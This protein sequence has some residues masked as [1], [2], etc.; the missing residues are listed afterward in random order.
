[1][2]LFGAVF[3]IVN[4][5]NAFS[6]RD[7]REK[8]LGGD[9]REQYLLGTAYLDGQG[10]DKNDWE[11]AYWFQRAADQGHAK[12]MTSLGLMYCLGRG[13]PKDAIEGAKWLIVASR[14]GHAPAKKSLETA[15]VKLTAG[16]RIMIPRM[17]P[18]TNR[19]PGKR[20]RTRRTEG[21]IR[22]PEWRPR[23][24]RTH[25]KAKSPRRPP[26]GIDSNHDTRPDSHS[27]LWRASRAQRL[28]SV[29]DAGRT[30]AGHPE[31]RRLTVRIGHVPFR[32]HP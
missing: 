22:S 12:A 18:R 20:I 4:E 27:R 25:A 5:L 32:A 19:T 13:V 7:T 24:T 28:N 10:V 30:V 29:S 17:I 9:V 3:K 21:Q 8:A 11:A 6:L 14:R 23:N 2:S 15:K 26:R 16:I 31:P 1:M